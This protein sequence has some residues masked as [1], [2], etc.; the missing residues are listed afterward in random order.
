MF[1]FD[2]PHTNDLRL[3]SLV[4]NHKLMALQGDIMA[5]RTKELR[6]RRGA[7]RK[8]KKETYDTHAVKVIFKIL[9]R[10]KDLAFPRRTCEKNAL[11][12]INTVHE[13]R[14]THATQPRLSSF[15]RKTNLFWPGNL[16]LHDI[17]QEICE[18]RTTAKTRTKAHVPL[19]AKGME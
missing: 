11:H 9:I 5:H 8:E 7:G 15:S 6:R 2:V 18:V 1:A 19:A 13:T 17:L 10:F 14:K 16:D 4:I 3:I 12:H